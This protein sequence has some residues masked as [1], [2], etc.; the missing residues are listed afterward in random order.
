[1]TNPNHPKK[2]S[3]ITI[4]PIW[5]IGLAKG[6]PIEVGGKKLV[7]INGVAK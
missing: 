4:Q 7:P 1:M 3:R 6:E 5:D 2:N